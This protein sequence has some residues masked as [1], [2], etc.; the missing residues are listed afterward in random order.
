VSRLYDQYVKARSS[1]GEASDERTYDRLVRTI[2]QQA[3]KIMEEHSA[4]GVE[5]QVVVKDNQVVLRAKPKP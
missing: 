5:F 3:P 2:E 4:K 1:V